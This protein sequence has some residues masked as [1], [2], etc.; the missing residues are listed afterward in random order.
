[1][2]SQAV[3]NHEPSSTDI[4]KE[5]LIA[6]NPLTGNMVQHINVLG[7]TGIIAAEGVLQ[8]TDSPPLLVVASNA[9]RRTRD[10]GNAQ[11]K[12]KAAEPKRLTAGGR[13]RHS[14]GSTQPW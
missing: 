12:E 1:M 14:S 8:P 7:T 4:L 6:G 2:L 5:N 9:N 3:S 10:D 13:Q 11:V